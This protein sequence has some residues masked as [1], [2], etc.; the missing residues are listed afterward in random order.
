MSQ[1][2][3]EQLRE[4]PLK[5]RW[6][7]EESLALIERV[8]GTDCVHGIPLPFYVETEADRVRWA[9]CVR[10]A[11]QSSGDAVSSQ[12]VQATARMLF[13]DRATYGD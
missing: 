6:T 2:T 11:A 3:A 13:N 10:V 12:L 7:P 4:F 1:L 5:E 9:N 8:D